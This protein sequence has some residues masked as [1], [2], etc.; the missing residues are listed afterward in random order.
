MDTGQSRVRTTRKGKRGKGLLASA[1]QDKSGTG[2]REPK[3]KGR[4]A[5]GGGEGEE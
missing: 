1:A 2:W 5:G 3:E 4:I